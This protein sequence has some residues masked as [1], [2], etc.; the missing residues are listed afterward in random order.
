MARRQEVPGQYA[1]QG[2]VIQPGNR[3]AQI[4]ISDIIRTGTAGCVTGVVGPFST[5]NYK[6]SYNFSTSFAAPT[7]FEVPPDHQVVY[8][9]D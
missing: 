6:F 1:K 5:P 9:F 4:Y 3:R 7:G 2:D 8:Y